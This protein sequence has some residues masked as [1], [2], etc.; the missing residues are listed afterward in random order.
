MI[1]TISSLKT[2]TIY[3]FPS[4]LGSSQQNQ[5][6][7]EVHKHSQITL[8]LHLLIIDCVKYLSL[9]LISSIFEGRNHPLIYFLTCSSRHFSSAPNPS[10]HLSQASARF[11]QV[12]PKGILQNALSM[13]TLLLFSKIACSLL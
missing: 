11:H 6:S 9:S 5:V 7:K 4:Q 3:I 10:M 8:T 1:L 13:T 12:L 2:Q